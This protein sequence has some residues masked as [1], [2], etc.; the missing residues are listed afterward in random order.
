MSSTRS[1]DRELIA[2]TSSLV[3]F[4]RDVALARRQRIVD[5]DE[6]EQVLWLDD[7]PS[8]V[9]P[10]ISRPVR[11]T[12]SSPFRGCAPRRRQSRPPC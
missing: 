6:Y 7:L 4:L 8:E 1:K 2:T 9:S 5:V 11:V 10:S 3:E 12:P